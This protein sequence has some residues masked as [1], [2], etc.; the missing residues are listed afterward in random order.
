[1]RAFGC[2]VISNISRLPPV[3]CLLCRNFSCSEPMLINSGMRVSSVSIVDLSAM[4]SDH[5]LTPGSG[6]VEFRLA[7]R[8]MSRKRNPAIGLCRTL[9]PQEGIMAARD[10][11]AQLETAGQ[12]GRDAA[13]AACQYP[14]N[15]SSR[16]SDEARLPG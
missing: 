10:K 5:S 4:D 2:S 6:T 8:K 1:M 12:N 14:G 3:S 9:I 11:G 15:Q 16:T 7:G 13:A